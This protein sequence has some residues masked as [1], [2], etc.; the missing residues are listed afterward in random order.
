[1][2]RPRVR[3]TLS[4]GGSK[5]A[6][7]NQAAPLSRDPKFHM[8]VALSL[9]RSHTKKIESTPRLT[10]DPRG[11]WVSHLKVRDL[12][13]EPDPSRKLARAAL[14]VARPPPSPRHAGRSWRRGSATAGAIPKGAA[15]R[16]RSAHPK[17]RGR[18]KDSASTRRE[19]PAVRPCTLRRPST[20]TPS[21]TRVR[22][23]PVA[24]AQSVRRARAACLHTRPLTARERR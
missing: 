12:C 18:S 15:T 17:P 16:R 21:L 1:M 19:I 22:A 9:E 4:R 14:A 8:Q 23:L 6:L 20:T 13:S 10:R 11:G 24:A 7:R 2:H 5:P 3:C